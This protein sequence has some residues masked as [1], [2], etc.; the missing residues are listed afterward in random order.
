MEEEPTQHPGAEKPLRCLSC[1]SE[2]VLIKAIEDWTMPILGFERHAY[3]CS[4][5]GSTEQRTVFNKQTK[6]RHDAEV[7]AVLRAPRMTPTASVENQRSAQGF[8]GRV[9]AKLRGQKNNLFG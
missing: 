3:M 6:E 5:C 9:L 2:M 1:G 4:A 7:V 8:F